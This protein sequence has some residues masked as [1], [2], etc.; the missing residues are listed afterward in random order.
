MHNDPVGF[1][2]NCLLSDLI[3]SNKKKTRDKTDLHKADTVKVINEKR[4]IN[5]LSTAA[6][7]F[8]P[9]FPAGLKL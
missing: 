7:Y 6:C 4:D 1:S 2:G 9:L 5:C 3:F 8:F